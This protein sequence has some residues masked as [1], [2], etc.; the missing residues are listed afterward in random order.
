MSGSPVPARSHL[1]TPH[2]NLSPASSLSWVREA[3]RPAT[4]HTPPTL[5]YFFQE[6][7]LLGTHVCTFVKFWDK[8]LN[9][10]LWISAPPLRITLLLLNKKQNSWNPKW[11]FRQSTQKSTP[12][13]FAELIISYD[14]SSLCYHALK[15]IP[16]LIAFCTPHCHHTLCIWH[17]WHIAMQL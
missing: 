5:P 17:I 15:V 16:L 12:A 10:Q 1:L 4:H 11:Y 14:R 9:S 8:I 2:L 13:C 6:H 3:E 7:I